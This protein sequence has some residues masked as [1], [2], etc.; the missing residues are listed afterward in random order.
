MS[1]DAR[2][3]SRTR[4]EA[5]KNSDMAYAPD[6]RRRG[7]ARALPQGDVRAIE[8]RFRDRKARTSGALPAAT[9]AVERWD[10]AAAQFLAAER[11]DRSS[12][13]TSS[14][15]GDGLSGEWWYVA[16]TR[17]S[18]GGHRRV[19]QV[20]RTRPTPSAAQVPIAT[21]RIAPGGIM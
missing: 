9:K 1:L 11:C 12:V 17:R 13:P 19:S 7:R 2:E 18:H 8:R 15:S 20:G 10:D 3:M 6:R 5:K 4:A 21:S 14:R 16:R